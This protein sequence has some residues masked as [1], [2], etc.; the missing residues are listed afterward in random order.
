MDSECKNVMRKY[1]D[2]SSSYENGTLGFKA[3]AIQNKYSIVKM[4]RM[5]YLKVVL[6]FLFV[7]TGMM[8]ERKKGAFVIRKKIFR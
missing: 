3:Y 6:R 1:A 7:I 5:T 2:S 4:K 8:Q